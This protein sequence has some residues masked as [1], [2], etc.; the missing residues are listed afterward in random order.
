MNS[1]QNRIKELE[2]NIA[3]TEQELDAYKEELGQL[4]PLNVSVFDFLTYLKSYCNNHECRVNCILGAQGVCL[5]KTMWKNNDEE[6][7]AAIIAEVVN[8]NIQMNEL[9]VT[10]D[11]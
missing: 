3:A 10:K 6:E 1:I 7:Q 8:W 2:T 11:A 5:A 9:G 4:A